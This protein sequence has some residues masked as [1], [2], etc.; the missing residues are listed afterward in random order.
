MTEQHQDLAGTISWRELAASAEARLAEV[1][2]EAPEREARWL[3]EEASGIESW[4]A[5]RSELA[6]VRSVAAFDRMLGRRLGGEPIQYVLGHWAFRGLDLAIDQRVLIPR[7][8]TE[9]IV[10][11]VLSEVSTRALERPLVVDLGTGSG[12]IGLSVAAEHPRAE[13]VATDVSPDALA[14]ARSNLAGLGMAG[15]RVTMHEGSWFAAL[16]E[17]IMG[18]IDVVVSNPP[19]I[20][21]DENL[22]PS[23]VDWEP[24]NALVAGPRG[25]EFVEH[26][27]VEA[28]SWLAPLGVLI[29]EMA[30]DQ[31]HS[32]RELASLAGY[33]QVR[34]EPDLTN[35][36]RFVVAS[37]P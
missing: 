9:V 12:A 35:R 15:S 2:V 8:E 31:T 26:L 1:G 28:R 6:R 14:V 5:E 16:P 24:H 10:D 27:L 21:A 30:S 11:L 25:I 7:P 17:S 3:A 29:I 33:S 36:P 19:Y 32:A 4:H 18:S 37:G 23:V 20:G 22:P 34:V 13:V